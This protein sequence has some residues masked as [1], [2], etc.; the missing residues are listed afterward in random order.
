MFIAPENKK[1]P[2]TWPSKRRP[3]F[4]NVNFARAFPCG[5][6][7]QIE[8]QNADPVL[9][10]SWLTPHNWCWIGNFTWRKNWN[11]PHTYNAKCQDKATTII[12][13]T[14]NK[15]FMEST[16]KQE[17]SLIWVELNMHER[18]LLIIPRKT[19]HIIM[20]RPITDLWQNKCDHS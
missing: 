15:L 2:V 20:K 7:T 10:Y 12:N 18:R 13:Q 16:L 1:L 9:L 5:N 4:L 14:K 19:R 11:N 3:S 6:E 8:R 17:F